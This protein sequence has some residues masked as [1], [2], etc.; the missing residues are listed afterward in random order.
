MKTII[1]DNRTKTFN[2]EFVHTGRGEC[3]YCFIHFP[4][5][6]PS[7]SGRKEFR[8]LDSA[9]RETWEDRFDEEFKNLSLDPEKQDLKRLKD[10]IRKEFC[11]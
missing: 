4:H 10:F 9:E 5:I 11:A 6:H 1:F 2:E 3:E 7:G 8:V